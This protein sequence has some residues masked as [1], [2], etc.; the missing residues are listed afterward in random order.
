MNAQIG[1]ARG[2]AADGFRQAITDAGLTPPCDIIADGRLHRF[3][4]NG[5][6]GDTAGWYV[7]YPNEPVPAGGFGCWRAG[8]NQT[9]HANVGR[10]LTAQ[11]SRALNNR[12]GEASAQREREEHEKRSQAAARAEEIWKGSQPA[13][14]G[15]PYLVRKKIGPHSLRVDEHERLVIALRK[16]GEIRTLQFIDANGEKRFLPGGECRGTY[17]NVGTPDEAAKRDALVIAE[18][19][20]TAISIYESTGIPVIAA[21][22]AN[23]LMPV[24]QAMRAKFPTLR[25]ILAADNDV[26][27]TGNPGF[28]EATKA[29]AA[30]NG[31]VAVPDFGRD[32]PPG[33]SDFN[34]LACL[35]GGEAVAQCILNLLQNA[36]PVGEQSP[37]DDGPSGLPKP[38]P[39]V[40]KNWR[41][42]LEP[43]GD[44]FAGN[45][46]NVIHAMRCAPE[47]SGVVRFNEF[48]HKVE[49]TRK[50][51]WESGAA[52]DWTEQDDVQCTAWLQGNR[53]KLRGAAT[54]ANCIGVVARDRLYH[55]VRD[56]LHSLSWDGTPRLSTWLRTYLTAQGDDKY[57]SAVGR[58]FLV[59]AVARIEKPGCQA[60]HMLVLEGK[61]GTGKSTVASILASREDWFADSLPDIHNK[62]ASMQVLGRWIIEVS[63]LRAIKGSQ[64]ESVKA[65]ISC[66]VDTFR[67]PYGRRTEQFPRQCI[68]IGTTNSTE[69]LRDRTGNRRFWPVRCGQIDLA[70]LRCDRDQLWAEA[71]HL[72]N[73]GQ[74]WH[75]SDDE[76]ALAIEQQAERVHRTELEQTVGCYLATLR[77]Q[78]TAEVSV[79]DVLIHGLGLN[80]YK[81]SYTGEARQHGYSVAE[82]L[83][84][85]GWNKVAR[86]RAGDDSGSKRTI[87]R[88]AG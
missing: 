85:H 61:Q 26:E 40:D 14:A 24:A 12:I 64:I 45:E 31:R 78:G 53:I 9:W 32:R 79:R 18:G 36:E 42:A 59:S 75:L 55:P 19:A 54:V 76:A 15:H 66:R 38:T 58:K 83:E 52:S 7:F 50:P 13:P 39:V 17:F 49:F 27:T 72:Y 43:S 11:E 69:Y 63:E 29:A 35:R 77:E 60:D 37:R 86:T 28:T 51:P 25:L 88:Y 71:R 23:N 20:S 84:L 57:L 80:P 62:D 5:R 68:F 65:F 2:D 44:G 34:D 16:G 10:E 46:R 1:H 70:A 4:S 21:M 73:A 47:L 48:S 41:A 56:F 67:P 30:V 87:Y 33:L 6:T 3:S 82:A 8:I 74:Q 81:D 22:S